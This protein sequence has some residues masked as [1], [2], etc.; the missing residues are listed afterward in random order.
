MVKLSDAKQQELNYLKSIDDIMASKLKDKRSLFDAEA[1]ASHISIASTTT[2]DLSK[3]K[4]GTNT[5]S[6]MKSS[7]SGL[8]ESKNSES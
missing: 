2:G 6:K 1:L 7:Q 8:K 5:K 4:G 3:S